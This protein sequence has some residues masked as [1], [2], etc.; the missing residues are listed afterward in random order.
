MSNHQATVFQVGEKFFAR[1][2]FKHDLTP[3][4]FFYSSSSYEDVEAQLYRH[5]PDI[6]ILSPRRFQ[7]EIDY[8]DLFGC[9]WD[10]PS[11]EL[12]NI[13]PRLN[14]DEINS[15]LNDADAELERLENIMSMISDLAPLWRRDTVTMS[16]EEL[17][18]HFEE[19]LKAH[20]WTYS[21]SNNPECVSL[22]EQQRDVINRIFGRLDKIDATRANNIYTANQPHTHESNN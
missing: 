18:K 7:T 1:V 13:E 5:F 9:R 4:P 3:I 15:I 22:G 19:C 8:I 6:E 20:D 21:D 17:F 11:Y 12:P 16:A 10:S 2:L 14:D